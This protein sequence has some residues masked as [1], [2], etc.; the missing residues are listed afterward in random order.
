[1]KQMR[2]R[3]LR[4]AVREANFAPLY[5]LLLI[6]RPERRWYWA[7]LDVQ[8]DR[9][10]SSPE[11]ALELFRAL[12]SKWWVR[13]ASHIW[14]AFQRARAFVALGRF[15]EAAEDFKALAYWHGDTAMRIDRIRKAIAL[16]ERE[17]TRAGWFE[18]R[19][20]LSKE[21]TIPVPERV[22]LIVGCAQRLEHHA[23]TLDAEAKQKLMR[24]VY[25]AFHSVRSVKEAPAEW[26]KAALRGEVSS[27]LAIGDWN[28]AYQV[29]EH[30]NT[31]VPDAWR[32]TLAFHFRNYPCEA[33]ER[34]ERFA[35]Q[36]LLKDGA[37]AVDVYCWLLNIAYSFAHSGRQTAA[38]AA[39]RLASTHESAFAS[40]PQELRWNVVVPEN[41][42]PALLEPGFA[43]AMPLGSIVASIA[44]GRVPADK[45]SQLDHFLLGGLTMGQDSYEAIKGATDMLCEAGM[46][47]TDAIAACEKIVIP[48]G[49]SHDIET[50]REEMKGRLK[51]E[52]VQQSV[53]SGYSAESTARI[54][55]LLLALN[56]PGRKRSA[57]REIL[58]EIGEY[59]MDV[60]PVETRIHHLVWLASISASHDCG[61]NAESCLHAARAACMQYENPSVRL[62]LMLSLCHYVRGS[63]LSGSFSAFYKSVA[64]E[65]RV[66]ASTTWINASGYYEKER[67]TF[68]NLQRQFED[69][70]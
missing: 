28:T 38:S 59:V 20:L 68:Q 1:M 2:E 29:C 58:E 55:E 5:A 13:K 11:A 24:K 44:P 64:M 17:P 23:A 69:I 18:M 16:L 45:L 49:L 8:A 30:C 7:L 36:V 19:E 31:L 21:Q 57:V 34:Y 53:P 62:P 37:S 35:T 65:G 47:R 56:Q 32:N 41:F 3:V 22:E 46:S 26:Q 4:W 50:L 52:Q 15:A 14:L 40:A 70:I 66:L 43:A 54:A 42:D 12:P 39:I 60:A 27:A 63:P 25:A 48:A 51:F 9:I 61:T 33:V 6:H 67:H 10:Q